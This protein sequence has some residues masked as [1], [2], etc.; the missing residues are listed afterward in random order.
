MRFT[1][2]KDK[3]LKALNAASHAIGAK[4]P[5]PALANF[6]LEL[7][8]KGLEVTGS[9]SEITILSIVP[10]CADGNDIIRNAGPGATLINAHS[11]LEGV[12]RM[13]GEEISVDIIDE[14]IAKVGDGKTSYKLPCVKADEYPDIDLESDGVTLDLKCDDLTSL[15]DATAFAASSKEQTRPVLTA[16]NI[17]AAD[18]ELSAVAT[19]SARMA[20]KTMAID[21]DAK[22]RVNVPARVLVDITHL[23]EGEESVSVSVSPSKILFHFGTTT[24]SSRLIAGDYPVTKAIIPQTYNYYLEVNSNELLS[25]MSRVSVLSVDHDPVVTLSMSDDNVTLSCQNAIA[26]S[27]EESVSTYNY[28]GE[29]LRVSFNCLFVCD[30]IKALK[31]TDVTLCFQGEMRPFVVRDDKNP[32][33]VQLITPM[34]TY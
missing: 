19:D 14:S 27:A 22:F 8:D 9:N 20:K 2:S 30:A 13:G 4:N 18:G 16:L 1:I 24:V 11:L 33:V 10:H 25:A 15:V 31:S 12:R 3:L 26:G 23:F 32:S 17:E 5:V 28:N 29:P 7:T 34:R 21:A 6:K